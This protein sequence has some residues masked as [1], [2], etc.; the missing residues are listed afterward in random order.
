M[1]NIIHQKHQ[2][3]K[4][5]I[6]YIGKITL[7]LLEYFTNVNFLVIVFNNVMKV[8]PETGSRIV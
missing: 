1:V 7:F 2:N 3:V 8:L 5:D 4:L 6:K